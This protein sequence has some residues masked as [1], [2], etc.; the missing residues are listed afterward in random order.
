MKA[1]PGVTVQTVKLFLDGVIQWPAQ[2][3]AVF[4]A[5]REPDAGGNW[6]E[7]VINKLGNLYFDEPI[8]ATALRS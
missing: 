6:I 8:L 3:A 1:S 5:Y 2:T 7:K 4:H